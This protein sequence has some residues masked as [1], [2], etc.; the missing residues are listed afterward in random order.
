MDWIEILGKNKLF[1]MTLTSVRY[2]VIFSLQLQFLA[3]MIFSLRVC[4]GG[5]DQVGIDC[6]ANQKQ[7]FLVVELDS[8]KEVFH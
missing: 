6:S 4:I 2:N 5:W 8:S 3:Q 1:L 7:L